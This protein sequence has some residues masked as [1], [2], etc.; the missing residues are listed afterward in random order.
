MEG[1]KA[2]MSPGPQ[3][4]PDFNRQ[5]GVTEKCTEQEQKGWKWKKESHPLDSQ[6]P[7][8]DAGR[9]GLAHSR[10]VVRTSCHENATWPFQWNQVA[11]YIMPQWRTARSRK[12]NKYSPILINP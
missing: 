7:G 11:L 5:S 10:W 1:A 12:I 9:Q 4:K 8:R 6:I 3:S 2:D